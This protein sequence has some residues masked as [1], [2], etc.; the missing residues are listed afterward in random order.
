MRLVTSSYIDEFDTPKLNIAAEI[1]YGSL[2]YKKKGQQFIANASLEILI[3]EKN[4]NLNIVKEIVLPIELISKN[5][6]V[7]VSQNTYLVEEEYEVEPGNYLISVT[8][9]DESNNKETTRVDESLVPDPKNPVANITNIRLFSKH[10]I[11]NRFTPETTYDISNKLDSVK[12]VFQITNNKSED[13][14]IITSRLLK[15]RSDTSTSR[16]MSW[17]NYVRSHIAYRGIDYDKYDVI[18]SSRRIVNDSGS[19]TIE[20]LFPNLKRGNYRLEITTKTERDDN[21]L[22]KA[23]DFSVKSPSYPSLRTAEE[24]AAPL[25]YLM[26]EKKHKELLSIK[27]DQ[28]LKKE[29][30]KFWLKNIKNKSL[31]KNTISLFYERVEEANKQFSSYKEGWK[32]DMGMIYILFGPPWYVN[33]SLDQMIWSYSYNVNDFERNFLF[34]TPQLK[35]KYF[36]FHNYLLVRN[37][38]YF[39]L[40]FLQRQRWK[41]GTILKSNL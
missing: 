13:P 14:F 18:S 6:S 16:P 35:N 31:A 32:T 12:F 15:F 4:E 28:E 20:L 34:R 1:I 9:T 7:T 19:I 37:N 24:L 10:S 36:P 33:T 2:I 39:N 23:R 5:S 25:I 26:D 40:E 27:N 21:E 11:E 41:D 38:A 29:I 22:F 17:P 30:D 8:L 3:R